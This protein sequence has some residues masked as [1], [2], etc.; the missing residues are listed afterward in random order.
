MPFV[1][2][3]LWKRL[4]SSAADASISVAPWPV[5]ADGREDAAAMSDFN[6]LQAI[7]GAVRVLRAEYGVSPGASVRVTIVDPSEVAQRAIDADSDT[8]RRLAK[9]EQL[10]V[11]PAP[12]ETGGTIVLEDRTSVIVPLGDL[13]DLDK[14]CARL[15]SEASKLEQLVAT[16]EAKLSNEQFVGR[17]PA[18]IIQKEREK[19]E[20][21]RAQA[22]TLREKRRGLGCA[23]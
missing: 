11:G 5:A 22:L 6:A 18:A 12:T 19:L 1:T 7:V 20:A 17:A 8:I 23:N 14:E 13:I 9:L 10:T 3:T 21:W 4:P 15:G 16:Q 2:E